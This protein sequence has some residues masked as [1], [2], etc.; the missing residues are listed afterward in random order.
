LCPLTAEGGGAWAAFSGNFRPSPG[1][2]ALITA[3]EISAGDL[4][5]E[6]GAAASLVFRQDGLLGFVADANSVRLDFEPETL[7]ERR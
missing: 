5:I 6:R 2:Y 1:R 3:T 7:P 4:E